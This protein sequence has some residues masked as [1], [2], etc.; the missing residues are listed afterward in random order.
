VT[1]GAVASLTIAGVDVSCM[2]LADVR[3]SVGRVDVWQQP[4]A[5]SMTVRLLSDQVGGLSGSITLGADC[6]LQVSS[7]LDPAAAA[8]DPRTWTVSPWAA[9]DWALF[10]GRVTDVTADLDPAGWVVTVTAAGQLADLGRQK[11][12]DE[13]W[14]QESD[15]ARLDRIMQLAGVDTAGVDTGVAGPDLI[16]KDIDS[17]QVA[18]LLR[19]TAEW[20]GGLLWED[21]TTADSLTGGA[22]LTYQTGSQRTLAFGATWDQATGTWDDS[23][24]TW[25]QGIIS[26]YAPWPLDPCSVIQDGWQWSQVVGDLV[27]RAEVKWGTFDAVA[28]TGDNTPPVYTRSLD[29]DLADGGA[30]LDL[31][32]R[33]V[34]VRRQPC[35]HLH[36][37]YRRVG[38]RADR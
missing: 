28:T 23:T 8:M 2:T 18:K 38:A 34:A 14:P 21:H 10:R 29:T 15:T 26:E 1:L 13:P 31:A 12:G 35:P 33:I 5:G 4:E 17:Q 37:L 19:E 6:L 9:P 20:A 24:R 30:A 36:W 16:A 32:N 27:T 11:I 3:V 22:L 7:T 25:D